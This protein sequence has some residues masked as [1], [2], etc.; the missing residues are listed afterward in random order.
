MKEGLSKIAWTKKAKKGRKN[1]FSIAHF[2][3]Q[4]WKRK[5]KRKKEKQERIFVR[6][7]VCVCVRA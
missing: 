4:P 2:Q 7:I 1:R 5:I 6:A 3:A